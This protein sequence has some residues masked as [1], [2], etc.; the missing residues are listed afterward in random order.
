MQTL[1]DGGG[2]YEEPTAKGTADVWIELIKG[3]RGLWKYK[4][5]NVNDYMIF[6]KNHYNLIITL[7]QLLFILTCTFRVVH[8]SAKFSGQDSS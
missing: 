7:R 6:K 2:I 3:E 1:C 5:T 8:C 4:Q